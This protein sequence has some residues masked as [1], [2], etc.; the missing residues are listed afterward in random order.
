VVDGAL[1]VAAFDGVDGRD[2]EPVASIAA[3]APVTVR[4][5]LP[6]RDLVDRLHDDE[7]PWVLVTTPDGALVGVVSRP[8][9]LAMAAA[10]RLP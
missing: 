5:A 6:V 10:D 8:R 4:P 9:L 1:D 2:D 7:T 3:P